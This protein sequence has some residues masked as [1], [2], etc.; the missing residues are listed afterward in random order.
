MKLKIAASLV[1]SVGM[2]IP[3]SLWARKKP[4]DHDVYDKWEKIAYVGMSDDGNIIAY[5]IAPQEGDSKLIIRN[6]VPLKKKGRIRELIIPRGTDVSIDPDGSFLYCRIS[7]EFAKTRREKIKK[8]KKADMTPDTLG[9]I[10]LATME[11]R[12]IPNLISFAT[13]LDDRKIIAYKSEWKQKDTTAKKSSVKSKSKKGLIIYRPQTQKSDTL[14]NVNKYLFNRKGNEIAITTEKDKKDSTSLAALIVLKIRDEKLCRDTVASGAKVYGRPVFSEDCRML[15][16]TSSNDTNKTGNKRFALFIASKNAD[17]KVGKGTIYGTW[18]KGRELVAQ[19]TTVRGTD[20][21]TLN[22][23]SEP[24]FNVSGSRIFIGAAPI[25]PPKDTSIVDFETAGLDIWN[26]DASYTPPQQKKMLS[27]T[28]TKTYPCVINL[29]K[30]ENLIP[31]TTSFEDEITKLKAGEGEWA[32]S[33]NPGKYV[34]FSMWKYNNLADL[35]LVSLNDGSRRHIVDSLNAIVKVSPAGNYLIWYNLDDRN[36]YTYNVATG[37]TV[38]LTEKTGF[39]FYD[40]DND[41]PM[42]PGPYSTFPLWAEGDKYVL[43][44]DRYDVW[45]FSPDGKTAVNI[46]SFEGRN[47]KIRFRTM[48]IVPFKRLSSNE[49]KSN[50]RVT[51]S[52]EKKLYLRLFNENDMRNGIGYINLLRPKSLTYF[53]DT[54]SFHT[55]TRARTSDRIIFIKGNFRNSNDLYF[56]DKGFDKAVKLSSINPQMSDYRWGRAELFKWNAYD[57]TPL[58]GLVFVPDD[59]KPNEKLPVMIYFYERNSPSLY[60]YRTPAPSRSIVNIPFYTSRGYICFIPDVVYKVGHPGESA[61]NCIVSGAEALCR[62][63][64]FADSTRMAIQGQSW[65]GYQTAYLVTRTDKFKAAGAGAPVG[66]MTSAYGGIRWGSGI[67]RAG[68]YE[69]GQSRIGKHMWEKGGLPL[70]LENSPVF[71]LDKVKT[72][73]LIMHNDADGAVPWYQGIEIFSDMRRLGKPVW[74]LEYNG[75]AHNLLHRRNC[76]DL[77]RRLQQFFDYY[78]MGAPLP[79]WM[80]TGVPTDRKGEYF[81]FEPAK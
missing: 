32:L 2:L 48:D 78:L 9:V 58:K 72:P 39:A 1:V 81:G 70:Y 26:W 77:S 69:C 15:T 7:P 49:V 64:S 60:E 4:L 23:N 44:P 45:K 59:I 75:E 76:K 56:T 67:V 62:N 40:E 10:N 68:Q 61:Y 36:F 35:S 52:S 41:V 3:T 6:S 54:V 5:Q 28:L 13:G 22:E 57:G 66:N 74:M 79:A 33:S 21:W 27:T 31:L 71:H 25:R 30:N 29:G 12:K 46:T 47:N 55:V 18:N 50:F 80:K 53:Q 24:Y 17:K 14:F 51:I 42:A 20:N 19:G 43:I 11:L 73:L 8:V 34:R 37:E 38:N 16:Y 65:G 63:Y